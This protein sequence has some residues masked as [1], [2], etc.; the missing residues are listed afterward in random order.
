[1]SSVPD[2]FEFGFANAMVRDAVECEWDIAEEDE[3]IR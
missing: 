3:E 1:M 2:L